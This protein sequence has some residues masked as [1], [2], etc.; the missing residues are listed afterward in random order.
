MPPKRFDDDDFVD[1]DDYYEED[2]DDEELERDKEEYLM[3]EREK[4]GSKKAPK[5]GSKNICK[6]ALSQPPIAKPLLSPKASFSADPD[7]S[8]SHSVA[9]L[10]ALAAEEWLSAHFLDA[11][12]RTP[13]PLAAVRAP[14][15]NS[16]EPETVFVVIGH[17]DAGKSTLNARLVELFGLEEERVSHS[18]KSRSQSKLAWELDVGQD[19][20]E[21]GVTIDAKSKS[22]KI[23]GKKFTAI[24]APGH[25]DFVPSMLLGAMQ[26]DA[27]VLVI[28]AA[29]FDSGFSR[30]G[31][32]KEHVSL[33]RALGI[34]QLVVV[35]NK[36][37]TV[38]ESDREFQLAVIHS[39]LA[40]FFFD[41]MRFA[42]ANV[43]LVTVSA[44][45]NENI[46]TEKSESSTHS[47]ESA[48]QQ[49]VPKPHGPV[50]RPVC[51]PIADVAGDRLSGRIDSGS[52]HP[53]EKLLALPSKQLVQIS[54]KELFSRMPGEY[55]ESVQFL[56]LSGGAGLHA[57]CVL[58]DPLFHK[59]VVC[60][61][62]FARILVLNDDNMP[63]V[64]GQPVSLNVHTA[65]TDA[66]V[67]RLIGK[68]DPKE[69]N[70]VFTKMNPK[71]LVKGD[72][73]IIEV[74]TRKMVPVEPDSHRVTGRVILRD[75]GVTVAA[76]MVVSDYPRD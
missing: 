38:P 54:S 73:A 1:Y 46:K 13:D 76:G 69:A 67:A 49:L 5:E 20:R 11:C 60:E 65:M 29:K 62:F 23:G 21:H 9:K 71:C 7:L 70:V 2:E 64:K 36:I 51:L 10:R 27:A 31:Q 19:E 52:I 24:D 48:L 44:L 40:D 56:D 12:L 63:I 50:H 17:V 3:V 45:L 41:E 43:K 30:G 74:S 34:S 32:T 16:A 4:K 58:V 68:V 25:Q 59:M 53:G 72:M 15:P 61:R 8:Y 6:P 57:G 75:R 33:I 35:V 28:D 18:Q 42:K 22:L 37:D 14:A 47:L 55:L 39:Q 26:A 66:T